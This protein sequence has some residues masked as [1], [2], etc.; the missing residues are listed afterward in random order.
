MESISIP[1]LCDYNI[2]LLTSAPGGFLVFGIL[3]AV[4]N[5]LKAKSGGIKKKGIIILV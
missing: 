3:I 4:V 1:V 2:P 5:K